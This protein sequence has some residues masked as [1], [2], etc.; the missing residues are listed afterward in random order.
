MRL[1][2]LIVFFVS[3]N[4]IQTIAMNSERDRRNRILKNRFK[5]ISSQIRNLMEASKQLRSPKSPKSS[6]AVQSSSK[7]ID[8][9][10]QVVR[11]EFTR[12]INICYQRFQRCSRQLSPSICSSSGNLTFYIWARNIAKEIMNGLGDEN[13]SKAMCTPEIVRQMVLTVYGSNSKRKMF[14]LW[15]NSS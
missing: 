12:K 7:Q 15:L 11:R 13:N 4:F 1:V 5:T 9:L 14:S 3:F 10:K 8:R 6:T 2:I